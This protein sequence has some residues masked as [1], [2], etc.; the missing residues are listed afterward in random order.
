MKHVLKIV[1][2]FCGVLML[3]SCHNDFDEWNDTEQRHVLFT[4]NTDSLFAKLLCYDGDYYIPRV[5]TLPPDCR[6]RITAY[7]YDYTADLVYSE[8]VFTSLHTDRQIKIR[9][10]LRGNTYR[11]VFVADVVRYSSDLDYYELF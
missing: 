10:L 7:C 9:H 6:L 11:F 5:D 2:L 1:M 3:A 4:F 8:H